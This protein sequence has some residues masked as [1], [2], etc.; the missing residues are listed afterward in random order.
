MADTNGSATPAAPESKLP[1][2]FTKGSLIT[3]FLVV[4]P[5]ALPLV[6]LHPKMATSRKVVWTVVTLILTYFMVLYTMESLKKIGEYYGQ[7]KSMMGT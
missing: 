3:A 6:W 2:Y 7:M 5:L 4:G 1:W